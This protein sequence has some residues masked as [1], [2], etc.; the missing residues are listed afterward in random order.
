[1][2][3]E[4][5]RYSAPATIDYRPQEASTGGE[6]CDSDLVTLDELVE[7]LG[8]ERPRLDEHPCGHHLDRA[9]DA[10]G[11]LRRR[12]PDPDDYDRILLDRAAASLDAI[13]AM[14]QPCAEEL[15]AADWDVDEALE[16]VDRHSGELHGRLGGKP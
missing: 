16:A 8:P 6:W 5:R 13:D 11:R 1:M 7:L 4:G 3:D 12:H 15:V 2:N 9:A 14:L 10:V